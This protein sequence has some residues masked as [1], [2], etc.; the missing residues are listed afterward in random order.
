VATIA[1]NRAGLPRYTSVGRVL[2]PAIIS[3]AADRDCRD[4]CAARPSVA[5]I[6]ASSTKIG[7]NLRRPTL[8]RTSQRTD[9]GLRSEDFYVLRRPAASS[10]WRG[11]G[12]SVR[13]AKR[14]SH[15]YRG[16]LGR[17]RPLINWLPSPAAAAARQAAPLLLPA[18]SPPT[19]RPAF[20]ALLRRAYNDALGQG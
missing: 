9:P 5:E 13:F 10:A 14:W 8:S 17:L 12:T 20:A 1:A 15:A 11:P 3:A 6:V 16:V 7:C 18:F 2:T 19:T 4:M